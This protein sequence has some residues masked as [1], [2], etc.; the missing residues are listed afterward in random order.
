[1]DSVAVGVCSLLIKPL[2]CSF[3]VMPELT[4]WLTTGSPQLWR[5][6]A[7]PVTEDD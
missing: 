2:F 7:A 1:M 6:E 5:R 3:L 4:A